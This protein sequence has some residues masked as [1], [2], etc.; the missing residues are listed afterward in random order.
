MKPE[1]IKKEVNV[2][3]FNQTMINLNQDQYQ[4]PTFDNIDVSDISQ[5]IDLDENYYLKNNGSNNY[6][7]VNIDNVI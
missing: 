1:L 2:N 7:N 6:V 4:N 3:Q 5:N